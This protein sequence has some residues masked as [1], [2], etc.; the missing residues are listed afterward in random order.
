MSFAELLGGESRVS[1]DVG[2]KGEAR[3]DHER[4]HLAAAR[5]VRDPVHELVT[6]AAFRRAMGP[7]VR[8]AEHEHEVRGAVADL[9][10]E[11]LV[12]RQSPAR[13]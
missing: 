11:A 5:A 8:L 10:R 9:G 7:R 2:R 1:R 6:V 13:S 12:G 3:R 4:E